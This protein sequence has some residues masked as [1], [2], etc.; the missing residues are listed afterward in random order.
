MK[1]LLSICFAAMLLLSSCSG[2]SSVKIDHSSPEG[3]VKSY[4]EASN[5]GDA[6]RMVECLDLSNF[7][8][9]RIH[10]V[11]TKAEAVAAK[12]KGKYN[13][14]SIGDYNEYNDWVDYEYKDAEGHDV[15]GSLQAVSVEGKWYVTVHST[16]LLYN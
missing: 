10:T 4:L 5:K 7:D 2:G 14:I 6:D 1:K 9:D 12:D 3:I 8:E 13:S 16:G 11:R 15:S